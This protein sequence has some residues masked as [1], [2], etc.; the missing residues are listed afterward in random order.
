MKL[1]IV[2]EET[3][4]L[5]KQLGLKLEPGQRPAQEVARKWIRQEYNLNVSAQLDDEGWFWEIEQISAPFGPNIS[6]QVEEECFDTYEEALEE[7]LLRF[8]I[9]LLDAFNLSKN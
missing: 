8:C 3:A 1:T 4:H 6:Q 2:T 5:L 9:L 7:G